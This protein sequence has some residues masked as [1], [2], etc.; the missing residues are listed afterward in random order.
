[1]TPVGFYSTQRTCYQTG[2]MAD[3]KRQRHRQ[4]AGGVVPIDKR[5]GVVLQLRG[6]PEPIHDGGTKGILDELEECGDD[7]ERQNTARDPTRPHGTDPTQATR[8]QEG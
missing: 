6:I 1:M 5:S 4:P 2:K 7:T 8:K 3:G